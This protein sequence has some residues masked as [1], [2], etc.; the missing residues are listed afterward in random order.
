MDP[1]R[2]SQLVYLLKDM[3]EGSELLSDLWVVGEVAD[4][5]RS[6]LGHRYFSLRDGD[7]AV[8]AVL[9]RDDMPGAEVPAGE[10]VLAHGRVT[11]YPQRGELQ[12]VCDFF[13]P[14]GVGIEA[15]RLERLR[16]RLEEE[17]LFEPSRKRALPAYPRRIGVVT[18]PT[19]AAIQDVRDV[20]ARRWPLAELVVS[21]A[22]VQGDQAP[23]S[24]VAA[25]RTLAGD[26]ALDLALV[27][28]GG[29]ASADLSA[30]NDESV[31]RA[32]FGFPVP[33][34]TGIGHE[35]DAS[36]ADF[37][38]DLRAPTPSAAA[39]RATPDAV[40]VAARFDSL[41]R[42]M[43]LA[44]RSRIEAAS[45]RLA[46]LT[47][48]LRHAAPSPARA[49]ERVESLGARMGGILTARLTAERANLD[50]T[51][52]Q[53]A[54]LN[55]ATTL[56]RGYAIV[57]RLGRRRRVVRRVKDVKAGNRIAVSVGDGA[58]WAEVN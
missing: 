24:I 1:L 40:E 51:G 5:T 34:V 3:L 41:E 2:V 52:A 19:G 33:V 45:A 46:N 27:V 44:A 43:A 9:F 17:G 30:F 31:V 36:L 29:G 32:V 39:A 8:R 21:P 49:A 28:R 25:L 13:R 20:L 14:E 4:A 12:F 37:A 57:E 22:L 11:L 38:A 42:A 23:A 55:P 16:E 7:G 54:A 50:R 53:I 35:T 58:F 48:S 26:D 15:A 10:R 6:R 18:S 47:A 56:A